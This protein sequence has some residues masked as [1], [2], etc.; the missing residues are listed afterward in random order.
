MKLLLAYYYFYSSF[1]QAITKIQKYEDHREQ[2]TQDI[3]SKI[4]QKPHKGETHKVSSSYRIRSKWEIQDPNPTSK[5]PSQTLQITEISSISIKHQLQ[6]LCHRK[7]RYSTI[8]KLAHLAQESQTIFLQ[9]I[10]IIYHHLSQAMSQG[11][12]NLN[13]EVWNSVNPK[14]KN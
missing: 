11:S 8:K 10:C 12:P 5:K 7:L 9:S 6:L 1:H 2:S 3:G 4:R 13:L 14:K